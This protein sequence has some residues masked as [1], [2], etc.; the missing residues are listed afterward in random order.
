MRN[1][2]APQG[3][4]RRNRISMRNKPSLKLPTNMR[5][6]EQLKDVT[7]SSIER[8]LEEEKLLKETYRDVTREREKNI[9]KLR[10]ELNTAIKELSR[11][12]R[13]NRANRSRLARQRRLLTHDLANLG[14]R[15][16]YFV[17]YQRNKVSQ[18]PGQV[19]DR[20]QEGKINPK[21]GS[22]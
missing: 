21:E 9:Q 5:E 13:E 2:Y 10:S 20:M 18:S 19:I 22:R 8:S 16:N 6:L 17:R 7:E 14:N 12:Q 4:K 3:T 11:F 15:F 1:S